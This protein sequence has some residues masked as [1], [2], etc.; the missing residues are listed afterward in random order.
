MQATEDLEAENITFY[1][2]NR[3]QHV[4]VHSTLARHMTN[5]DLDLAIGHALGWI[6]Y[7]DDGMEH[8]SIFHMN[9]ETSPFGGICSVHHFNPT[10]EWR[11]I[12]PYVIKHRVPIDSILSADH[13]LHTRAIAEVL[14]RLLC[15][16]RCLMVE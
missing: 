15:T 14:Y 12:M 10:R 13:P 1:N 8:G 2:G 4:F 5:C 7:P 3:G 6:T 11:D 9:P 16:N